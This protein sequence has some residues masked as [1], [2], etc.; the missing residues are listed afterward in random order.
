MKTARWTVLF[1][2]TLALAGCLTTD[3]ERGLASVRR[4]LSEKGKLFLLYEPPSPDQRERMAKAIPEKLA[5]GGFEV[6]EIA[7]ADIGRAS[8]LA[9]VAR[10]SPHTRG[11]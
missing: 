10:P 9:A 7:A 11:G 2:S 4:L 5:A 6:L 1:A 8:L 3:A